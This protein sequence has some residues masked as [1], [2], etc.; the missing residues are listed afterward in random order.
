MQKFMTESGTQFVGRAALS[1]TMDDII[2][3]AL[4]AGVV[5]IV[6]YFSMKRYPAWVENMQL[7]MKQKQPTGQND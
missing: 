6:G 4:G 7:R 5:A 2:T 3:D 1:D